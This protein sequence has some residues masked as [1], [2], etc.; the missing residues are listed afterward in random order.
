MKV[1]DKNAI[2]RHLDLTPNRIKQ[3]TDKGILTEYRPGLYD[4]E[5]ARIDYIRYLRDKNPDTGENIDY[6]T[7]RAKLVRVKR[8]NEEMELAVK[9]REL[10]RA[11]DIERVMTAML[12][13]FKARLSAIPVEQA[14]KLLEKKDADSIAKLL[15]K[16][17]KKALMELSDFETLFCETIKENENE[18]SDG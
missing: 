6:H 9:N 12:I 3:L 10:H 4:R 11:E 5:K 8:Q 14:P 15:T 13:N 18:E 7:E 2:A 1:Y 17:I 16:E